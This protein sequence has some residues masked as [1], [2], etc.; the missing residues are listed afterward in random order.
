MA[1]P[2]TN[3]LPGPRSTALLVVFGALMAAAFGVVGS[4]EP[5]QAAA[6]C[7]F[8]THSPMFLPTD[9]VYQRPLP[10]VPHAAELGGPCRL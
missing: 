3:P 4:A 10:L 6:Q 7:R 8:D 9:D 2:F 1:H 5:A